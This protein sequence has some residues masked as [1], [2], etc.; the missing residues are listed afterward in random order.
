MESEIVKM[1]IDQLQTSRRK[2]KPL[3]VSNKLQV[4]TNHLRNGY[5]KDRYFE[6]VD[7]SISVSVGASFYN[8]DDSYEE[9]SL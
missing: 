7:I 4:L 9:P 5:L 1:E 8:F 6:E 3:V 2:K